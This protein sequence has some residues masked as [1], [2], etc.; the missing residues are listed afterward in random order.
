LGLVATLVIALS[1][2]ACSLP[3]RYYPVSEESIRDLPVLDRYVKRIGVAAFMDL[4]GT[5]RTDL[6]RSFESTLSAA[7]GRNCGDVEIVANSAADAPAF[8]KAASKTASESATES[9][10]TYALAQ[11]ARRSGFQAI[12]RGRLLSLNHRVDRSGWASFRE[13][14][15]FLDLRL[16]A[17]AVDVVTAA[18]IIQD[19]GLITLPI[20]E[21]TGAAIDAG[22]RFEAPELVETITETTIDMALKLCGGIRAHPW[23]TVVKAVRGG[24]MVLAARPDAGLAPGD[25]LAVFDGSRTVTGYDDERFVMAGFRQGTAVIARSS[26]GEILAT[27]EAGGVFPVG[28]I[29]IP[30]H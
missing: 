16:Q 20:D 17:E 23:Q 2:A 12:V 1:M 21:E 11:T 14:H 5:A 22:K 10:D 6:V 19:S 7:L 29:L 28:S 18:K 13:S 26:G 8:L 27:S 4:S 25:R 3:K 9:A 15:H 30:V 24:E